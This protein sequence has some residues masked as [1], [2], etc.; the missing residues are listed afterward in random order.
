[1]KKLYTILA[2]LFLTASAFAQAPEKMSYQAVVRD[3]GDALVTS[4]PVGM[5]ISILQTTATGTAVYVETQTPTTNVNGLVS[6]EI[7]TGSVVSGDFTSIDWSTD[8]YFIKTEIDP[9]GGTTY[10]ITGTSQLMSVPFALYAKTSGNGAGPIG[11]QGPAGNDGATGPIGADGAAGTNGTDGAQ[12]IQGAQGDI[13]AAGADGAQGIQGADGAT[14][15]TGQQG[16]AGN[17]GATGQQGL[18]GNDGATGLTGP[19]GPTGPAGSLGPQGIQG[20]AGINGTPGIQGATGASG[21]DGAAGAPGTAGAPGVDGAAGTN[22]IDGTQGIQGATGADGATGPSGTNGT[23]GIQGATGADGAQGIQGETGAAGTN[24]TQPTYTVN[25]LYPELG[26]YVIEI[27]ADGTH[28][29]VAAMQDQGTSN[30]YQANDL[31]SNAANH[32]VNG[33]KFKD[34]RIPTK[35]E[36]NLIY[37]QRASIGAASSYWSSTEGDDVNAWSQVFSNGFQSQFR[38]YKGYTDVVRAVRAF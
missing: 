31:L 7:G 18:A 21:A 22:G 5:Q 27:N 15:T 2:A 24:A 19:V 10:T 37:F 6:L 3:S 16:P 32:D 36:L 23:Q 4:Q 20:A 13:G 35:R 25:T 11:P 26:G 34:W 14:G 8:S 12:G 9:A 17:D 28:G 30:W 1:M 38:Y 29:L 33:A